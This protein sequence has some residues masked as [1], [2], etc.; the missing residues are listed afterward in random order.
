VQATQTLEGGDRLACRRAEVTG[1]VPVG[2]Q[3]CR[4]EAPLQVTDRL[5]ALSLPQWE[6]ARQC[7]VARNSSSS[8]SRAPL[9]LAP[10]RR[11][12]TSPPENTRSVG[13]LMT[14]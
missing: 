3:T 10:T 2:W 9:L 11:F 8:W 12:E 4:A 7:V 5:A 6:V 14:L 1:D 13:M